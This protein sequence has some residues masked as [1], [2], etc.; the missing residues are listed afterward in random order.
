[1]TL[2]SC[3]SNVV[4]VEKRGYN[5]IFFGGGAADDGVRKHRGEF[6]VGNEPPLMTTALW[7]GMVHNQP[8]GVLTS[9]IGTHEHSSL[10]N[11]LSYAPSARAF[12]FRKLDFLAMMVY[13]ITT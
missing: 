13:I 8:E 1:M 4:K 9:Q 3:L 11:L 10:A 7:V 12:H 2:L 5:I 6:L